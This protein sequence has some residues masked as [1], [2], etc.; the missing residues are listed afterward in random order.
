MKIGK[1]LGLLYQS[2]MLKMSKPRNIPRCHSVR[3]SSRRVAVEVLWLLFRGLRS[4]RFKV[5]LG[6]FTPLL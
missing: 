6:I 1:R 5:V 2:F 3:I 4:K